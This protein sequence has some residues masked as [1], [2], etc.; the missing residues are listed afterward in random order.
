MSVWVC[1][2]VCV[3]T[4][5]RVHVFTFSWVHPSLGPCVFVIKLERRASSS[6]KESF[7]SGI[8]H[9]VQEW[10]SVESW[11]LPRGV[12]VPGLPLKEAWRPVLFVIENESDT[13]LGMP[14]E[15]TRRSVPV[16]PAV[17]GWNTKGVFVWCRVWCWTS[18]NREVVYGVTVWGRSEA[19]TLSIVPHKMPGYLAS[20]P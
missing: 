5:A 15:K 19:E 6:W 10:F 18:R 14:H 16:I 20:V 8:V 13:L 17:F 9:H 12:T 11:E 4:H 3:H 7:Y 2:C 1:V